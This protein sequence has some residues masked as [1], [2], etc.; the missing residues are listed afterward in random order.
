MTLKAD[1]GTSMAW[2]FLAVRYIEAANLSDGAG[3]SWRNCFGWNLSDSRVEN[4][5]RIRV[6]L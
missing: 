5:G 4:S 6:L 2:E 3:K 1:I